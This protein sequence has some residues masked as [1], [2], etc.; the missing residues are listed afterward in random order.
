MLSGIDPGLI[1]TDEADPD[2]TLFRAHFRAGDAFGAGQVDHLAVI[3]QVVKLAGPVGSDGEDVHAKALDVVDL[4]AFVFF[5]DDLIGD[6]RLAERF[7]PLHQG[8][9]HIDFAAGFVK[10]VRGDP[11]DQPVAERLG[12]LQQ[13]D[14]SVVKQVVGSV[15]DHFRHSVTPIVAAGRGQRSS[16]ARASV[17]R[18]MYR[19]SPI[20]TRRQSPNSPMPG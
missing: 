14:M 8:L 2:L 20:E 17:N 11:D 5:D 1:V 6:P 15:S 19:R 7:D 12:P 9:L 16:S 4:L 3:A 18:S 13:A 10:V